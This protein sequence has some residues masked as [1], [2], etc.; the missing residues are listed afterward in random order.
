MIKIVAVQMLFK[1]AV[2]E[3]DVDYL[4]EPG[5]YDVKKGESL[6]SLRKKISGYNVEAFVNE[7]REEYIRYINIKIES[8]VSRIS[9]LGD[10]DIILFPE[11]SIPY[12][13][14]PDVAE[15]AKKYK[16]TIVAGTHMVTSAA[17]LYYGMAGLRNIELTEK[18]G[19]AIAPIFNPNGKN[20]FQC[21]ITQSIFETTLA[22]PM[23]RTVKR[24]EIN[25]KSGETIHFCILICIDALRAELLGK[26]VEQNKGER[27]GCLLLLPAYSPSTDGFYEG[28]K[29]ISKEGITLICSNTSLYGNSGMYIPH[30]VHYRF[31]NGSDEKP[32]IERNEEAVIEFQF[33]LDGMFIKKGVIDDRIIGRYKIYPIC[34][35]DGQEWE[36]KY[37]ILCNNLQNMLGR[38]DFYEIEEVID[39]FLLENETTPLC[40]KKSLEIFR[41]KLSNYSGNK[42]EIL[43]QIKMLLISIYDTQ[44]FL[45]NEIKRSISFCGEQG[46]VATETML[47]LLRGAD[48]Y[49]PREVKPLEVKLRANLKRGNVSDSVIKSFR[50]RGNY[51]SD[52]QNLMSTE[53]CKCIIVNGAYGIGKTAFVDIAFQKHYPDWQIQRISLPVTV[54]FSMVLEYLG[55]EVGINISAD[56][57]ARSSKNV[58]QPILRKLAEKI[59]EIPKRCIVIDDM[60]SV[61]ANADGKDLHI[62]EYFFKI[63]NEISNKKGKLILIGSIWFPEQITSNDICKQI[64]LKDLEKKH[65]ERIIIYEMRIKDMVKTEEA[66]EI[67]E[68]IFQIV[69]GHPLSAKLV[70][71]ILKHNAKESFDEIDSTL[72]RRELI[73]RLTSMINFDVKEKNIL[74]LLST[75]RTIIHISKLKNVLSEDMQVRFSEGIKELIKSPYINF[76]GQ[77]IEMV[78]VF[79]VQ[80]YEELQ[81]QEC[82]KEYHSYALEY[83]KKL[84]DEVK[85][86]GIF[87]P[88]VYSEITFHYLALGNLTELKDILDGNRETLKVHAKAIYQKDKE[89][90]TAFELYKMLDE[91]F[92]DDTEVLSYLGRCSARLSQW[93]D[94]T[95]YFKRAIQCA[96]DR[97]EETWYLYRDWAHI[98]IRY[99]KLEDGE[100][101][102]KEAQK[103]LQIETERKEDAAILAAEGYILDSHGETEKAI[104]KYEDA[105]SCVWNHGFAIHYYSNLLK[106]LGEKDRAKELLERIEK[107]DMEP[108]NKIGQ[109][110]FLSRADEIDEV[111]DE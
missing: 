9:S 68:N 18:E 105:L 52:F 103:L 42:E 4:A 100:E 63:I 36:K 65:I 29:I 62:I 14:L 40:V 26:V 57:I 3:K 32:K 5:I 99:D 82:F 77:T 28:A 11:Y 88:M 85:A 39:A 12:Q 107:N 43:R 96:K 60:A 91:V 1:P 80:F 54:R 74:M 90:G 21:K 50:G 7:I 70:V 33:D 87:N 31:E 49:K 38:S 27:S 110:D 41:K 61:F 69:K 51:I 84:H 83:Y 8:I 30:D 22:L 86:N 111:D 92:A 79:R 104:N 35:S 93:K 98:L 46:T 44:V 64:T 67:S 13:C 48:L 10:V 75:F 55:A 24:F 17:S 47:Y 102:L 73:N 81:K 20:D 25:S 95:S 101:M 56:T 6:S 71:E 19:M 78:E 23:D 58:M 45:G 53:R 2:I 34:Y 76:D 59:F 16:V 72:C 66:P 109:Y 108:L 97:K 106:R 15:Y 94:S 37:D 89:Y